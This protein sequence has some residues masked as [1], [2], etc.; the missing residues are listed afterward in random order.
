M[1]TKTAC[2]DAAEKPITTKSTRDKLPTAEGKEKIARAHLD[3]RREPRLHL[4]LLGLLDGRVP[5]VASP[6]SRR[7][8]PPTASFPPP[9]LALRLKGSHLRAIGY[10]NGRSSIDLHPSIMHQE[11]RSRVWMRFCYCCIGRGRHFL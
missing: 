10:N 11:T 5:P 3:L 7:G 6:Y 8:A 9:S 1:A 4:G 2:F